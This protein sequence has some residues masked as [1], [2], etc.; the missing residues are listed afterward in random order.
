M[1]RGWWGSC[2]WLSSAAG[3]LSCRLCFSTQ[4]LWGK[5]CTRACP[6]HYQEVCPGK[7]TMKVRSPLY[8]V[9][10]RFM[11]YVSLFLLSSNVILLN[12]LLA[13][14]GTHTR[15]HEMAP[16]LIFPRTL[17]LFQHCLQYDITKKNLHKLIAYYETNFHYVLPFCHH[18]FTSTTCP[19]KLAQ[20]PSCLCCPF[21]HSWAGCTHIPQAQVEDRDGAYVPACLHAFLLPS[22]WLLSRCRTCT[23]KSS[24]NI[25]SDAWGVEHFV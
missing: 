2:V 14:C 16:S 20:C 9:Y 5:A 3:W 7:D 8:T 19:H 15:Y 4:T 13:H 6:V 18:V 22:F 12:V 1:S 25:D 24:R 10:W 11:C 21:C 17:I 23:A